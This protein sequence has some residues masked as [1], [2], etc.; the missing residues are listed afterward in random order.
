MDVSGFIADK[1]STPTGNNAAY[2]LR[3][4]YPND[5]VTLDISVREIQPNYDPAVGFVE[6]RGYRR[7]N[8]RIDYSPRFR[9]HPWIQGLEFRADL[10][11]QHDADNRALTRDLQFRP[12]EINFRDGS[13]FGIDVSRQY[14]RSRR[15]SRFQTAS[16]CRS[17]PCTSSRA[18][19]SVVTPPTNTWW[20]SK[21]RWRSEI[22]SQADDRTTC[23][24]LASDHAAA[25]R[26]RW[27]PSTTGASLRRAASTPTY[28]A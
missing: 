1:R 7:A 12:I 3:A 10:D 22:S 8:P 24:S 15:T 9:N 16:S 27:K 13:E 4:S 19:V 23:S 18:T 5:P 21:Q 2:G 14:Q 28:F 17:V 26:S 11:I 25:S 20:A 6:R